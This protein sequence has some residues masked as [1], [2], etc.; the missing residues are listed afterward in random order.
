VTPNKK[1]RVVIVSSL[2]LLVL[3]V[4]FP[5][6]EAVLNF[7][8]QLQK[9]EFLGYAMWLRPPTPPGAGNWSVNISIDRL[10]IQ[11]VLLIAVAATGI[12]LLSEKRTDS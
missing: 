5:P 4:A 7:G 11:W 12:V 8:N 1:Q 3:S 9:T 6:Y 2:L 10:T